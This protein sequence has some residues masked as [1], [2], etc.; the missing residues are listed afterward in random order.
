VKLITIA[1]TLLL[2]LTSS[3]LG[4][5]DQSAA[6]L[7]GDSQTSIWSL[8]QDFFSDDARRRRPLKR[9]LRSKSSSNILHGMDKPAREISPT[10]RGR[11]SFISHPSGSSVYQQINVYRI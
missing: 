1:I 6:A 10:V 7:D 5:L 8:E 2:F 3:W 9:S 4:G 11:P